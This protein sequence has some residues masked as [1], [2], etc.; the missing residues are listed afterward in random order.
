M[1]QYPYILSPTAIAGV[2]YSQQGF[3]ITKDI[4]VSFDYACYGLG[5]TGD[6]GFTVFFVDAIQKVFFQNLEGSQ[7]LTNYN[8]TSANIVS[9]GGPGAGLCYSPMNSV[10]SSSLTGIVSFPGV[11]R[12]ALGIGF[13]LTGHFALSGYG[14]PGGFTVPVPNSI[15][16][17][18]G[19]DNNYQFLYN[20]GDLNSNTSPFPFSLYQQV[21]SITDPDIVTYNR[22]RVR[23]TDFGQRI[24]VDIKRPHDLYYTTFSSIIMPLTAWWPDMVYCCLGFATGQLT[25]IFKVLNFNV[26]G[27]FKTTPRSWVYYLDQDTLSGTSLTVYHRVSLW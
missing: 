6:E 8:G 14:A 17:R 25:T 5:P 7:G 3:D 10:S 4:V 18:D 2:M 23:I 21:S 24:F 22:I 13:D 15:T 19:Y 12:A 16:I 27:V 1:V 11:G 20:S 26:N 9:G